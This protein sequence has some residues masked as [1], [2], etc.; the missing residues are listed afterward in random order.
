MPSLAETLRPEKLEDVIGSPS[1]KRT[2]QS[3]IDKDNFPRCILFTGPVGTG[4]ST[5]A[6]I[7]ARNCQG[8]DGWEDT[9]IRQINAGIVG[10]V[11]DMRELISQTSSR[12]LRGRY[13]VFILE[14]CHRATDAA[15]DALLVPMETNDSVVWILT[16]S[17]PSKLLPAIRSRCSAA[18]FDLKPLRSIEINQLVDNILPMTK[19]DRDEVIDFLV[20]RGITSPREIL[21]VLDLHLS[22]TPLEQC[23]SGAEHEPLY[24]EVASAV[25][26]GNWTKC[27]ATLEKIKTADYR[28]MVGIVSAFLAGDLLKCPVGPRADSIATCL[29]GLGSNQFQD[30]VAYA[31][32][33]ALFYKCCRALE[34][35]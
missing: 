5:L 30:G 28:G 32:T 14:E 11:D 2:I 12:P 26:N 27:A 16:S 9:D 31:S 22:G 6:G 7:V 21:G 34:P 33:K 17:D 24:K 18:T 20:L 4:K 10:K 35:K 8:P 23:I 25:L 15:Q 29:V 1:V 3:W 19:E 13:R